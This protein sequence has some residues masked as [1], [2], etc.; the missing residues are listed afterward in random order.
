MRMARRKCLHT[1]SQETQEK[2]LIRNRREHNIKIYRTVRNCKIGLS[3][4]K[5][6]RKVG[7]SVY[8]N[9]TLDF[10]QVRNY[11]KI[12]QELKKILL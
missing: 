4:A 8:R 7:S 1:F 2:K 6:G 5:H 9:E 3:T 11:E 10:K 12:S